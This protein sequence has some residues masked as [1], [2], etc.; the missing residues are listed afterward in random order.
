MKAEIYTLKKIAE[1]KLHC[2][3]MK[4]EVNQKSE[5]TGKN[6]DVKGQKWKHIKKDGSVH[7]K[8][9]KCKKKKKSTLKAFNAG[10]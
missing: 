3:E 6:I 10:C 2:L 1:T 7:N 4:H 8:Q 9:K 5:L